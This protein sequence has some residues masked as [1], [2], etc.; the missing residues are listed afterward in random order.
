MSD[1]LK[2]RFEDLIEYIHKANEDVI[3]DRVCELT[4]LDE[5]VAALCRDVGSAEPAV[6]KDVQPLMAEMISKLD[7]LARNLTEFQ[8]RHEEN[9]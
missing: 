6:A 4:K 2:R 5:T 1:E 9:G 8:Q 7:E 3:G